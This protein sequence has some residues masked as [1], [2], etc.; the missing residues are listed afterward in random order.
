MGLRMLNVF[1]LKLLHLHIQLSN[2]HELKMKFEAS[3]I[4]INWYAVKVS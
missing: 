4:L 2:E 3:C 1:H